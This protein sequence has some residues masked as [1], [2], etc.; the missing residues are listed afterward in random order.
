MEK[1]DSITPTTNPADYSDKPVVVGFWFRLLADSLDVGL[2]GIVGFAAALVLKDVFY[3]L[4]EHGWWIGLC[5]TFVYTGV[6]QSMIGN[7]QT[8]AKKFL[9]IHLRR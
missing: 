2:L 3:E 6:L 1:V 8:L 9:N 7:G 5:I 4:G